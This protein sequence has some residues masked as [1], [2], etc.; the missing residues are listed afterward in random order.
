MPK[1]LF[2]LNLLHKC[3]IVEKSLKCE[4]YGMYRIVKDI[5]LCLYVAILREKKSKLWATFIIIYCEK[6]IFFFQWQK[7]VLHNL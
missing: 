7:K 5:E 4:M 2:F 1:P 3:K 6:C